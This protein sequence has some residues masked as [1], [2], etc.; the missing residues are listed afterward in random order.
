MLLPQV[1]EVHVPSL[2][3][4]GTVAIVLAILLIWGAWRPL[5]WRVLAV[6][7]M[8]TGVGL[9]VWGIFI[10]ATK[11]VPLIGTPAGIIATGAGVLASAIVLLVI[12]FFGGRTV[13]KE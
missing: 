2:A 4:V 8:G 3:I 6:I 1:Y 9:L 5:V 12:S 10:A 13:R 11:E 7:A